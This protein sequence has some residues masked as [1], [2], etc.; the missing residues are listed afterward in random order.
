MKPFHRAGILAAGAVVA[1]V[2]SA[3][4]WAGWQTP[5]DPVTMRFKTADL[6][7]GAQPEA[8][9]S[10]NGRHVTIRWAAKNIVPGV[11]VQYY[12]VTRHGAGVPPAHVCTVNATS[13]RDANVPAGTWT[14]TVHTR[15]ETWEGV[16]GPASLPVTI[17]ASAARTLDTTQAPVVPAP[18]A[19]AAEPA[20]EDTPPATPTIVPDPVASPSPTAADPVTT[21]AETPLPEIPSDA[22]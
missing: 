15:F 19:P 5:T 7:V 9:V 3:V 18:A 14:Y 21:T 16:D 22:G 8:T 20:E 1:V 10:P 13:C 6:P 4:A 12:S 2:S 17:A 11:R